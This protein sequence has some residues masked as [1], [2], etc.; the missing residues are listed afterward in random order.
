MSAI[1]S[2]SLPADVSRKGILYM[3]GAVVCFGIV[4]ALAKWLSRDFDT[5]QIVFFRN[6]VGVVFVGASVWNRPLQQQGG[7][8]GLLVFRGVIGT[9]SLYLFFYAVQTLGLGAATTYQ[10]TY[11]IFLALLSWLVVGETLSAREW[12]AIAVGLGGV[13]FIFRPDLTMPL[14]NHAIGLSNAFLTAVAYLSIRQLSH[15]YD[16]R[17]IVLSFML[18]GIVMPFMSMV[19]GSWYPHTGLDFLL[20]TFH[21]PTT[22]AHWAGLLALGLIAIGG[23]IF[24]T[25]AFTY[26]KAGRI[27][28]VG[29]SNIVFSS[30]L[31]LWLGDPFPGLST[32]IGMVLIISGGV[33]V[34]LRK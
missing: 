24:L 2:D 17:A 3:L 16:T 9:L 11:P 15:Y 29:Y 26:D 10:Y 5:V 13:L 20:G 27:A 21:W 6:V 7:R 12:T 22:A 14:R 8:L 33:M 32:L 23:Q 25:E 4:G 18:S 1:R 19:A 34:S 28:A 30:V 31:G